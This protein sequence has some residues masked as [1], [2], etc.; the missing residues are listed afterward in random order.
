VLLLT[1]SSAFAARTLGSGG[2]LSGIVHGVMGLSVP[3]QII[4]EAV[5]KPRTITFKGSTDLVTET[6]K[7]SED[8]VLS[9]IQVR[10]ESY[11]VHPI[12]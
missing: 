3:C 4:L 8:A 1:A 5:D 11:H 7:A 12:L 9:V 6:D 2:T 10:P